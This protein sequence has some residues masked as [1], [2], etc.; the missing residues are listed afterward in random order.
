MDG[1]KGPLDDKIKF[2]GDG[3]KYDVCRTLFRIDRKIENKWTETVRSAFYSTSAY[4]EAIL[5]T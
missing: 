2:N 4:A 3:T 1:G 5:T